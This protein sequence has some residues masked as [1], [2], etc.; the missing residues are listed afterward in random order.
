MTAF[1][2]GAGPMACLD[3]ETTAADPQ[4]ARTVEIC[5]A[6]V[7][8]G[9]PADVRTQVIDPGVEVPDEAAKI[10]GFTTERVQAEGKP[11]PEVLDLYLGDIA[12]AVKSGMP[13]VAM[14]AAYDVTV[15]DRE[16]RRH[17]LPTLHDR[18]DGIPLYVL[19]PMVLDKRC[20]KYRKRVSA[21]QGARCLKTL[22]QTYRLGWD[23]TKAHAAEYDTLMGGRVVWRIG[24][25]SR[26]SH[27]ELMGIKLG[28][29]D[30]PAAMR[31]DDAKA[32]TSLADMTLAELHDAQVRWYAQQ[33]DGLG[34]YWNQT[35]NE[36]LHV[37]GKAEATDEEKAAAELEAADLAARIDSLS[38]EW[39]LRR[40]PEG[41]LA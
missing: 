16:A 20:V 13:V 31:A 18:L 8:P 41:A 1:Q 38:T 2:L 34:Q 29:F 12:L 5:L 40:L 17:D 21:E 6:L 23:D 32:F 22:A 9:R 15:L 27:D 36:A 25:L 39:P 3:T 33:S 19:D 24:Q 30:P 4:V 11:A 26:R 37:A 10:H 7:V 35:R 14:N 28:P